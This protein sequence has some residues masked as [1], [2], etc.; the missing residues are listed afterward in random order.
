MIFSILGQVG[1]LRKQQSLAKADW[2]KGT[3]I[4]S[5][6]IELDWHI[7]SVKYQKDFK[8]ELLARLKET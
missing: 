5:P 6:P 4:Q 7:S 3:N 2:I 8:A 1:V